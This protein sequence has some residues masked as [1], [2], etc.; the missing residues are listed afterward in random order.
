MQK[1]PIYQIIENDIKEQ[2]S[3]GTLKHGQ[4]INSENELKEMYS[5]S[6][7]TVRQAL[8]NL[9]NDGYL[10]RHKGKGT[11]VSN[12]KIE[13]KMQ[14]LLGFTE[15]MRRMNKKVRSKLI[16]YETIKADDEIANKL[17]LTIG[18][19]VYMIERIRYGDDVPVLFERLYIP[20]HLFKEMDQ[21]I[22]ESS[23]Y[24]YIENQM[25]VKVSHCVQTLE[26]RA[27]TPRVSDML[28]IQKSS[29][30][31]YMTRNTFLDRGFPFEYVKAYYRADQYRFIQ[32]SSR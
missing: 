10:Y 5:V 27:A 15:E 3:N 19:E 2:I 14:G 4:M 22:M 25:N 31:L 1:T 23:F 28:E 32:H 16:T 17:F 6:R 20:Q 8:N 13:K 18:D 26:A 30:V 21:S 11:F 12:V 29:P 24:D 7:M 9:V